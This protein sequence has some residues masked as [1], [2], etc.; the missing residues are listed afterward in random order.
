MTNETNQAT[1]AQ[2]PAIM[3]EPIVLADGQVDGFRFVQATFADSFGGPTKKTP[4]HK[5]GD[6]RV[7]VEVT[8][9]VRT[10]PA[11]SIAKVLTYGLGQYIA[12]GAAGSED[13]KGYEAGIADRLRKLREADFKRTAGEGRGPATDT[14]E[15]RA[16]K[17]AAAAIRDAIK[18]QGVSADAKA[19]NE[20]A[21]KQVEANPKWL[22]LAKAQLA[23]EAKLREQPDEGIADIVAGLMGVIDAAE[24]EG[25]TQE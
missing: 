18:A 19:I 6:A 11:E 10:L 24:P 16:R 5:G 7:A 12:D 15:G 1:E 20:A 9:D 8:L 2:A 14:P 21:Q 3:V 13:Q 23:D 25:E 4:T 22:K 17:L